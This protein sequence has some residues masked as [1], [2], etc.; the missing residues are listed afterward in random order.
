MGEVPDGPRRPIPAHG[1]PGRGSAANGGAFIKRE[2]EKRSPRK[3]IAEGSGNFLEQG[4]LMNKV[5]GVLHRRA[6]AFE[7][8]APAIG[9]IHPVAFV[10]EAIYFAAVL[11]EQVGYFIG[12]VVVR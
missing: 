4:W 10:L 3:A 8:F 9:E 5:S 6:V 1:F 2:N 7:D 11:L 12:A